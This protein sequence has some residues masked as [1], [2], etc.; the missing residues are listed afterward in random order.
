M[1]EYMT[2]AEVAEKLSMSRQG[3]QKAITEGRLPSVRILNKIGVRV[4]DMEAFQP[5]T[6]GGVQRSH[7]RR[8]PGRPKSEAS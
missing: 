3:V 4:A 1:E 6:Y 2:V 7:K 5:A 8:G